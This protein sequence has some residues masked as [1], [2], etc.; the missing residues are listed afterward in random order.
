MK[1]F[2]YNIAL[3]FLWSVL[4]GVIN[5]YNLFF[6]LVIGYLILGSMRLEGQKANYFRKVGQVIG[7]L[8]FFLKEL[9]VSSFRVAYDVVTPTYHMRPGIIA[10]PL[11]AK[12]DLEITSLANIISLTPGTLSL[13]VSEDK[14]LLYIHAMF[15]DDPD[16]LR[17]EIK[18]GLEKKLLRMLR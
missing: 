10:I 9:L 15:I 7:F 17:R 3:A 6:G 5:I 18:D 16:E 12:T 8:L 2:L 11:D 13:D 14:K 1:I 4:T